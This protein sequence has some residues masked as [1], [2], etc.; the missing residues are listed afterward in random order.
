VKQ[1]GNLA[2]LDLDFV[3]ADVHRLDSVVAAIRSRIVDCDGVAASLGLEA[4]RPQHR[5]RWRCPSAHCAEKVEPTLSTPSRGGWQCHR[6]GEKG[7][8]FAL[9]GLAQGYRL[10]LRGPDFF[11]VVAW[12]A[13]HA[14]L[15]LPETSRPTRPTPLARPIVA[16]PPPPPDHMTPAVVGE[17]WNA[18]CSRQSHDNAAARWLAGRG[19]PAHLVRSG[20]A[21]LDKQAAS[22]LNQAPAKGW[23]AFNAGAAV[24]SPLR[25]MRTGEVAAMQGR[26]FV[27][28]EK[29]HKR[30]TI[31]K[32]RDDDETPHV[33]GLPESRHLPTSARVALLVEGMADT[34]AAEALTAGVDGA[35]V[36]GAVNAQAMPDVAKL[37]SS[38]RVIVVRHI[39]EPDAGEVNKLG[40][41]QVEALEAVA[42]LGDRGESFNW[43]NFRRALLAL[44][45]DTRPTPPGFDLA[46]A[47]EMTHAKGVDFDDVRRAFLSAIGE[48]APPIASKPDTKPQ[49]ALSQ[50][51]APPDDAVVV[52]DTIESLWGQ[53]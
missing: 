47:L 20:F 40:A 31:G 15:T 24:V 28:S 43:P 35:A 4:G 18:L 42:A 13:P 36:V 46:A 12:L 7:D 34:W 5:R 21:V 8:A 2:D 29:A 23:L 44:G 49:P 39:D 19:I 6:C 33:F 45:V 37:L 14:G 41:G 48:A 16:A 51:P 53:E 22:E 9:V 52:D 3:P 25:S 30:R 32:V 27:V 1:P 38:R 10:P 50:P 17:A 26:V 11:D